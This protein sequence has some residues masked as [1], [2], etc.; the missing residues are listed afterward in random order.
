[1]TDEAVESGYTKDVAARHGHRLSH[2][3]LAVILERIDDAFVAFD[4]SWRFTYINARADAIFRRS[5]HTPTPVGRIL[6]DVYPE[7]VGTPLAQQM[8]RAVDEQVTVVFE[9]PSVWGGAWYEV[10]VYPSADG[11][12]SYFRD[13]TERKRNEARQRFLADA[14]G[15]LGESLDYEVTLTRVAQLVVPRI[16]DWC[17]VDLVQ[18]A[19][20]AAGG[21]VR[22]LAVAHE[23][24]AKVAW[25]QELAARY[26]DDANAVSGVRHVLRT[27][28]TEFYPEISDEMLVRGAKDAE[29]LRILRE[30]GFRSV[31]IVPLVAHERT[32]GAITLVTAESGRR[33]DETD[34]AF[35]ELLASRAAV[36]IDNARLHRDLHE[37]R[38]E[39]E[40]QAEELQQTMEELELAN[41]ELIE[42]VGEA[43]TARAE[44][45][46]A[47]KAKAEFLAMM[48]HELR[49]PLNAIAGYAELLEMG[50]RGPVT[51]AQHE[52]LVRIRRSQEHLLRLINDVLNFAKLE[53]GHIEF[54]ITDV[55]VEHALDGLREMVEPQLQAH[56]LRY[57]YR[58][59]DPS[60]RARADSEKMRQV[61]LNLL[62][63]AIKFTPSGGCVSVWW[64]ATDHEVRIRVQDTGIGIPQDK[65]RAI[66]EPFVQVD[67]RLAR[68]SDGIGLGLAISRDLARGMNGE[69]TAESVPGEGSVFTFTVPRSGADGQQRAASKRPARR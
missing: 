3:Q 38:E 33:Y 44:A 5:G 54:D 40:Q 23:D 50:I 60:V 52:D 29:H 6:W 66:F 67:R 55:G 18:D 46:A 51:P 45:E 28:R 19:R 31:L 36:A 42:R 24:P 43:Q 26:P 25:A 64:D 1:M 17:A 13:I 59:G 65:L 35:A 37:A 53:T 34:V 69:L 63:N 2:D 7:I 58:S 62:S 21:V 49:T 22:R 9:T 48:S 15:I 68:G 41:E 39:L 57:E 11:V 4:R 61:V 47:N 10:R 8:Q 20:T 27:G 16:A 12:S 32:L 56:E 14:G 30:I